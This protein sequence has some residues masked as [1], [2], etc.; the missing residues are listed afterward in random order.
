MRDSRSLGRRRSA[1]ALRHEGD[2]THLSVDRARPVVDLRLDD[3][4]CLEPGFTSLDGRPPDMP[5]LRFTVERDGRWAVV[6]G[7]PRK[8]TTMSTT[9]ERLHRLEAIAGIKELTAK[10][11][12]YV[13]RNDG[14]AIVDLFTSDGVLDGSS[15][16]M[17]VVRGRARQR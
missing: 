6:P 11:C 3:L 16:G 4:S 10:Y 7:V 9:E 15:A 5:I 8:G 1:R 13:A 17:G 14:A 12:L 2:R